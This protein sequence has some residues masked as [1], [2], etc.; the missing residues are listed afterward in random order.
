M[1]GVAAAP[2]PGRTIAVIGGVVALLVV[3]AVVAALT[4][5]SRGATTFPS[6]SPEAAFQAY[7]RAYQDGDLATAYGY[8][9][10]TVHG[11]MTQAQYSQYVSAYGGSMSP[12]GAS[13]R[14]TVDGVATHGATATLSLT[15]EQLYGSGIDVQRSTYTRQVR[16]V[17]ED[18]AWKVDEALLG[19]NPAPPVLKSP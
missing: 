8:F 16:L 5:G 6:G 3:A 17:Q 12:P 1:T 2:H 10:R 14:L 19:L 15:V 18:G 11:Q 9:S 7:Y 13:E 4:L